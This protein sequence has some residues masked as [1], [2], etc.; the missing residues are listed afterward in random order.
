VSGVRGTGVS[1][2]CIFLLPFLFFACEKN[3]PKDTVLFSSFRDVPGI[4]NEEIAAIENIKTMLV[5]SGKNSFV[6]GMI[7]DSNVFF[8]TNGEISGYTVFLCE[9]LTELFGFPFVPQHG[10]IEKADFFPLVYS[11]ISFSTNNPAFEPVV[12]VFHK[13]LDGGAGSYLS[14]LYE[15]GYRE[16]NKKKFLMQLTDEEIGFIKQNPVI[17]LG[18]EF[19]YYPVSY[20]NERYHEWQGIAHDVLKEAAL[21]TGLEFVVAHGNNVR[22]FD[23][24]Q[25]LESG[26]IDMLTEVI[27]SPER[28]GLFL[29]PENL[30]MTE[31]SVL[32]SRVD[33][34]NI[35]P[36]RIYSEKVGL[37][38]GTAHS[39]FFNN[40]F[41]N[42]PY[43]KEYDNQQDAFDALRK[44]EVDLV[45]NSYSSLLNLTN[46]QEL[47]DYKV[48][49]MFNNSFAS[50]FGFNK[51]NDL[52][53]S[54]INKTLT[55]IDTDTIAERW[56][57]R[58]YDYRLRLEQARTPWLIAAVALSLII[59]AL[60]AVFFKRTYRSGKILEEVVHKRTD[61][62][63]LQ[64]TTLTT[65]FDSIPDLIFTKNLKLNFLHC[66]KAFLEHFNKDID[67]VVGK[68]DVEMGVTE[69]EA[70]GFTKLD[71]KVINERQT[72]TIEEYIPRFDG[73]KPFYET[74]KMPLMLNNNVI[75]ILGIS[76]NITERKKMEDNMAY[77]YEY[78]KRLSDA[79]ARIT[80]SPAISNGYLEAS[81]DVIAQEGCQ[82][83]SSSCVGIWSFSEEK[84]SLVS[85]S[86]YNISTQRNVIQD[87]YDLSTRK[88]YLNMLKTER[89]IVMN[90]VDD[91]KLISNAFKGYYDQMCGAL[92]AP[93]RVGGKLF[94]VVCVEQRCTEKYPEKREW[95]IEE[96]NFASSLADL[97]AL[98]LSSY[99]RRIARDAAEI[100]SQTKSSFLANMSHEIRTP[101]NA[102]LGVTEILMQH[103]TMPKDMEEGL[104]KI[105][106]SCD[107]L[108]GIINDI[109]DFSKIEA[110]KLDIMP[111]QYK[112]A[113]MINDSVH[114]NMMRIESKPIEFE[115]I[116]N[117]NIPA[118]LIGDEL[119]IKQILNNLLS[120][121][122]KYTDKGKI[123][124]SVNFEN[125]NAEE[126][127]LVLSIRDT[128]YG[129]TEKQLSEMFNEYS[130]FHY[131]NNVT[132]EGTGLGLA[133][134]QRL[135][136]LMDGKMKVE[137]EVGKGTE[138]NVYL[139]QKI[140]DDEMLGKDVADNL[141]Q[142]RMSY[143]KHK[144]RRQIARDPMPYGKVLVVDDV[145]TNI[146]VAVGLMKLYRLKIDTAMSG[147]QA[148]EKIKNGEK[149]DVIFMDH[150]MPEMDG[151]E[152]VKIIRDLNYSQPIVALTANAVA[153]QSDMFLQNGFDDFISK[154][155]D[156][157]QLNS[158]LNKLVRDKQ[159]PDVIE[160]AR[161]IK[162]ESSKKEAGRPKIDSM[163]IDPFIRDANKTINILND[164]YKLENFGSDESLRKYTIVVHG[165]K[166]SLKSIMENELS[167]TAY[168]LEIAGKERNIELIK[169]SAQG[170]TDSLLALIKKLESERDN[171][172]A[173]DEES[174][175]EEILNSGK[176]AEII[177]PPSEKKNNMKLTSYEI[178]GLDIEKG[179]ERY[180]DDEKTY[181]KVLRSYSASV[182][183]MLETI[184][185]VNEEN[186]YNYRVRVHGIKGTSLDICAEPMSN[187]AFE[188]EKA[189]SARD[190]DFIEKNNPA[191]I[192][193]ANK[194]VSDIDQFIARI[195]AEN[196]KPKKDKPEAKML[197]RL[198]I[199]CKDFDMDATDNAM[200]ELE[201][202]QYEADD[203]LTEWLRENVDRMDLKEIAKKLS[204][205]AV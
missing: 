101:M 148:I 113:S 188:L 69:A 1:I 9:W 159:P 77:S 105:Y 13:A 2:L 33:Y 67:D 40:W 161:K 88:E 140:V 112:V 49:V 158:V 109:L 120:N 44:A 125:K 167:D 183:S 155:I 200:E 54:I 97:M 143:M 72:V 175:E 86:Y 146:Y 166:S 118:K 27:R 201:K 189:S 108:L 181:I 87:N 136:K 60:V 117:E 110:G 6:Y 186:L 50:T 139:P 7:P 174:E 55:V 141:R 111:N 82:A 149:Y 80:K 8:N 84:N 182:R 199:A 63:A 89:V 25:M 122:F 134:T 104:G 162:S 132:V 178:E 28:E 145:E 38:K 172:E 156:I 93:I 91:C 198:L 107:L 20:Y 163:L 61:E 96:Q 64:T 99:E 35:T 14:E 180:N 154:P 197:A 83:L 26:E 184:G 66:N 43:T 150:M 106:N 144:K 34:R 169:S 52:L 124:L 190:F 185:N 12:S 152:A 32:I 164:L 173:D 171:Y 160:A 74:I 70:E 65:L 192:E 102:I 129:M 157:R 203:G 11:P 22:F 37:T 92:D 29:W 127:T 75:G 73:V 202:Y 123:T 5:Q 187:S 16:Y 19:D 47:P 138:F 121:A 177:N 24:L 151:I 133:I 76:R 194:L 85:M 3:M 100:A 137:S 119:R 193:Q 46:Y 204:E 130:R 59:L 142:F 179:L 45:M 95:L 205:M 18:S 116:I 103:E 48:N 195:A 41:P 98:A 191:F 94:G 17:Q 90:N 68:C 30:V 79:L 135:V 42:H 165:I 196:P 176:D 51:N 10:D 128:G 4:S 56:R 62:L 114:L 153:G 57:H 147:R 58:T 15:K 53:C 168:K 31:R 78:A 131:E 115:L 71:R 81:A 36:D 39:E 170:F 21:L 23:L 126:V